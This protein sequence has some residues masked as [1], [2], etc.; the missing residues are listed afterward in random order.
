MHL[1]CQ[2]GKEDVAHLLLL[3]GA[4]VLAKNEYGN[5]PSAICHPQAPGVRAVLATIEK[6]GEA[7]LRKM[8]QERAERLAKEAHALAVAE[9][10]RREAELAAAA[11]AE[12]EARDRTE[13][14]EA[15]RA[16]ELQAL[17]DLSADLQ[18]EVNKFRHEQEERDRKIADDAAAKE[19]A[20]EKAKAKAAAGAGG[21]AKGKKK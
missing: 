3:R 14:A 1:A 18:A 21:K 7:A 17:Q 5:M 16:A 4:S 13:R 15:A 2:N 9:G 8:R 19:A 20:A 12:A 11:A 6:G 10:K